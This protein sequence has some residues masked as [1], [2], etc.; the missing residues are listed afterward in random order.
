MHIYLYDC[1]YRQKKELVQPLECKTRLNNS[2]PIHDT[3]MSLT[4]CKYN[5]RKTYL[6]FHNLSHLPSPLN[7]DLAF[8]TTSFSLVWMSDLFI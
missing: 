1:N 7:H 5:Q 2:I 8:A 3:H 6:S 4:E